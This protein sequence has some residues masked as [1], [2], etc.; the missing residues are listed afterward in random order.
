[1]AT[2][3]KKKPTRKRQSKPKCMGCVALQKEVKL[4]RKEKAELD[5]EADELYDI[6]D[7]GAQFLGSLVRFMEKEGTA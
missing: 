1:M 5:T 2:Q 6:V 4:L 7:R 3:I